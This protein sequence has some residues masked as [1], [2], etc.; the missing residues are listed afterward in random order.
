MPSNSDWWSQF[1]AFLARLLVPDWGALVALIP[2][3]LAIPVVAVVAG[4]GVSWWRLARGEVERRRRLGLPPSGPLAR[5]AALP[6]PVYL[7][8]VGVAAAVAGLVAPP[9]GELANL[10][11]LVAGLGLGLLGVGL[12]VRATE[13]ADEPAASRPRPSGAAGLAHGGGQPGVDR[14]MRRLP[15]LAG[16]GVVVVASFLVSGP[17]PSGGPSMVNLPLLVAGLVV[18][19]AVVADTVRQWE[20]VDEDRGRRHGGRPG[21]I[22]R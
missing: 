20:G 1:L 13:G 9:A 12:T 7:V 2:L 11:L 5:L 22:A 19:L 17:G 21:P 3:V 16:A 14:L 8:P 15:W 4:L 6:A 18:A 10:P